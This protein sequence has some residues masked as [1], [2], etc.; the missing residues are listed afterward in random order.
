M[1]TEQLILTLVHKLSVTQQ[2]SCLDHFSNRIN[3]MFDSVWVD[4]LC[5][6]GWTC[7]HEGCKFHLPSKSDTSHFRTQLFISDSL[8]NGKLH[9][10]AAQK[11]SSH[12]KIKINHRHTQ[13]HTSQ[14]VWQGWSMECIWFS[15]CSARRDAADAESIKASRRRK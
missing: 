3:M 11:E 14:C 1:G 5:F 6:N 4:F 9:I 8:S 10:A 12:R 13:M 15:G 2:W 7:L